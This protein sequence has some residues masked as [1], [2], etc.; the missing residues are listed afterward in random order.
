MHDC[1]LHW[2]HIW[3]VVGV[4]I[5]LINF[6]CGSLYYLSLSAISNGTVFV[7]FIVTA[8]VLL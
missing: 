4:V 5:N 7:R 1:M 6:T 3:L 2:Y 8:D